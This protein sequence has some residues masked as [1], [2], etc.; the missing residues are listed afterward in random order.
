MRPAKTPATPAP[1]ADGAAAAGGGPSRL[2]PSPGLARVRQ[3][4][5]G[6]VRGP[7]GDTFRALRTEVAPSAP[8]TGAR[9]ER[10]GVATGSLGPE[11]LVSLPA[12]G[13][14]CLGAPHVPAQRCLGVLPGVDLTAG[15][16]MQFHPAARLVED[17]RRGRSCSPPR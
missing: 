7:G 1:R 4:V 13:R 11:S 2:R 10:L 6:P 17:P 14:D 3:P 8:G 12:L 15:Q 16:M 5:P 9:R